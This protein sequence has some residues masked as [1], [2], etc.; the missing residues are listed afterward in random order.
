ML[1]GKNIVLGIAGGIA[2]YKT[3][4]LVRELRKAGAP[5]RVVITEAA[6]EF[7]SPLTLSTVSGHEVVV[8]TFPSQTGS[9]VNMGTWH[10]DLGRWAD[11]MV[12]A[13]A[14]ANT[15]AKLAYGLA[16]NAVTSLVLALRCPLIVAP[17]M[18]LDMWEH[19]LTQKN[20]STLKE[21]GCF[22]LPPE[23][24][25]LAS[26]LVGPGR[27]PE[28]DTIM[29]Y[30]DDVVN[31]TYRDLKGKRVLV[32]AGPTYERVDPVRFL[33]NRSSGKMGFAIA[34]AAA[35]RGAT[36]TLVAGPVHVA[37]PRNV[38][39]VDVETAGQMASAVTSNARN[40]D[41]VI[42]AAAVADYAPTKPAA[43]KLKKQREELTIALS[44]T[45]DILASL[46]KRKTGAV[47]VGFALETTNEMKNA[48]EKLRKKNLDLV[49]LNNPNVKGAGFG[50]DTNV[51]T[52]IDRK[53]KAKKLPMMSK[54]DVA[55]EILNRV[56]A[57]L[58]K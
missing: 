1:K 30:I 27:L 16:D 2:A 25:E 11:V 22:V 31:K 24:G 55:T 50:A 39:R 33:G 53:G 54:F 34:N 56:A 3:P 37:T 29:K 6:K 9:S 44:P 47:L 45:T 19:P 12:I 36:V 5:V 57:L 41:A 15:I 38:K 35:L 13:P 32:T 51:V 48:R 20:V 52:L 28:V 4:F 46:G 23:E 18:D 10:I 8:G 58:K 17:A 40:A 43:H 7:V 26:G 14:T 42:M 49:V 21:I